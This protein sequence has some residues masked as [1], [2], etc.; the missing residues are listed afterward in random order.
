MDFKIL[1]IPEVVNWIC[2]KCLMIVVVQDLDFNKA[3][4]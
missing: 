4:Q 2:K 3:A 1:D